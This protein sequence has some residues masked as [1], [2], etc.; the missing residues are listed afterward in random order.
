MNLN[1]TTEE[2]NA[3][4]SDEEWVEELGELF[5]FPEEEKQPAQGSYAYSFP[6]SIVWSTAETPPVKLQEVS[7]PVQFLA[8][9]ANQQAIPPVMAAANVNVMMVPRPSPFQQSMSTSP[10]SV[11][12][13]ASPS[14]STC[15]MLPQLQPQPQL[16]FMLHVPDAASVV[17]GD[18][19]ASFSYGQSKSKQLYRSASST[20][21]FNS[22]DEDIIEKKR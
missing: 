18:S 22:S 19:D 7:K 3:M 6:P 12:P 13:L 1:N 10:H 2:D 11:S 20:L 4:L 21:N 8:V 14:T 17:S 5:P 15:M 16:P 9:N